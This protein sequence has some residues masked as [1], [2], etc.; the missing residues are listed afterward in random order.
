MKP[1]LFSLLLFAGCNVAFAQGIRFSHDD[2]T[3]FAELLATA[4][5]EHKLVFV[6]AYTT[7]CGPCKMMAQSTFTDSTVAAYYNA[8]FVNAKIDM[9]HGQGVE[10]AKRY[11]VQVYPSLLFIDGNGEVV[12]RSAGY[13]EATGFIA[14]GKAAGNPETQSVTLQKRFDKGER[15]PDFLR[16]LARTKQ[17]NGEADYE[18]VFNAYL[19][20]QKDW[21]TPE[22]RNLIFE[23][24]TDLEGKP[25]QYLLANRA[26]FDKELTH[27]A[28][29]E[30]LQNVVSISAFRALQAPKGGG[31]SA[32]EA[33]FKKYFPT[34]HEFN[35]LMFK[36]AV[37]EQLGDNSAKLKTMGELCDRFPDNWATLNSCAWAYFEGVNDKKELRR[38]LG[39]AEKSIKLEKN[40]F[41]T[42]THAALLFKLGE[43]KAARTAALEA[44]EQAKKE[45]RDYSTTTALL[46][47]IDKK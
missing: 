45:G 20:T 12:H 40:Y 39:W 34:D 47:E 29:V 42:D 4:K 46:Q 16:T 13:L 32:A 3:K 2:E 25:F 17:A 33:T 9:E 23:M 10:L 21:A 8:T 24:A 27:K 22:T 15:Q 38:A 18:P 14:L 6:D 19:D 1:F 26:D 35:F 7:W 41:N 43:K 28:V 5:T 44:I 36:A 30:R 11:G 37:Y 31:W